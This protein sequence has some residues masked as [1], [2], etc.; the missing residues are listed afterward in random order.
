[1]VGEARDTETRTSEFDQSLIAPTEIDWQI[2]SSSDQVTKPSNRC[3]V[4]GDLAVLDPQRSISMET[5]EDWD[6]FIE[7]TTWLNEQRS[8]GIVRND[9]ATEMAKV[10]PKRA[11]SAFEPGELDNIW[12]P[13]LHE[14]L[15]GDQNEGLYPGSIQEL[16]IYVDPKRTKKVFKEYGETAWR[17]ERKYVSW[18]RRESPA[19]FFALL[20]ALSE[21]SQE[22]TLLLMEK[23]DLRLAREGLE[24]YR[25]KAEEFGH[26]QTKSLIHHLAVLKR[27][28]PLFE[29]LFQQD[30]S[31]SQA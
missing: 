6:Y 13:A 23:S 3:Y 29:Q 10:D 15:K 11:S 2:I 9:L 20:A 14:V 21:I 24:Y 28:T 5:Q 12:A 19:D 4:I 27:L 8:G 31:A 7:R 18:L 22:Q 17:S 16:L 25:R 26:Y 30:S 1:M